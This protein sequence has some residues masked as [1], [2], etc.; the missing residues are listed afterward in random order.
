MFAVALP[1]EVRS[2][3][4]ARDELRKFLVGHR[5]DVVEDAVLM[6]SELVTNAVRY[7]VAL[8][9]VAASVQDETLRVEVTDDNPVPPGA[10]DPLPFA[11][12]G[13]GLRIVDDL[14]DR[15]GTIALPEGK[16]VW[17]EL[18]LAPIR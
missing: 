15:W 13:R 1:V 18:R 8:L 2:A 9:R 5:G 4:T 17:F 16:I 7:T 3:A 11:T 10:L 6:I 12:G 14:A